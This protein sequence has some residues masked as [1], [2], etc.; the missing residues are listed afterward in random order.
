M[1][2]AHAEGMSA[3]SGVVRPA[4]QRLLRGARLRTRWF[5]VVTVGEFV[6]FCVPAAVGAA[7]AQAP[8]GVAFAA[9]LAAGAVEGSALGFA[10]A[11]VLRRA[12][13]AV[14]TRRWTGA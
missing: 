2:P 10:Q 6:G 1:R 5:A 13:P 3:T 14:G 11:S 7:T 4:G 8:P 9:V 12:L